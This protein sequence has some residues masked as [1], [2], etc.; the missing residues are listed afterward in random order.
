MTQTAT[1]KP[2]KD[3]SRRTKNRFKEHTLAA[4]QLVG[5]IRFGIIH[6]EDCIL[7]E[8]VEKDTTHHGPTWAGWIPVSEVEGI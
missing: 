8:S 1:H 7:F 6:D 4:V 2:N 5:G 3:A